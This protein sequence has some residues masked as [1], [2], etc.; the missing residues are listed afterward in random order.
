VSDETIRR[1]RSTPFDDLA[2]FGADSVK[3]VHEVV[4]FAVGGGG[5]ALQAVEFRGR[6]LTF[7]RRFS[8]R[9]WGDSD[10]LLNYVVGYSKAEVPPELSDQGF[11]LS[12]ETVLV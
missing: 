8:D 6:K 4:D 9:F 7:R 3:V 1:P 2:L 11:W 5:V 10:G 12:S